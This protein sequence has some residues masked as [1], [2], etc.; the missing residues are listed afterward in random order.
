MLQETYRGEFGLSPFK[1][2]R[3][4]LDQLQKNLNCQAVKK[5]EHQ[6]NQ[7]VWRPW[8]NQD[9]VGSKAVY[10]EQPQGQ[11]TVLTRH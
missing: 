11:G 5:H 1:D 2:I 9:R 4:F 10:Y 7:K 8:W 3:P 6:P